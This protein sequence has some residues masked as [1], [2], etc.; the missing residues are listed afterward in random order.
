[1]LLIQK[2]KTHPL[3]FVQTDVDGSPELNVGALRELECPKLRRQ[4][5]T[6][7]C[8]EVLE[9]IRINRAPATNSL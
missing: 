8:V 2:I 3:T 1:M 7:D 6:V 9:K 5:I 4:K